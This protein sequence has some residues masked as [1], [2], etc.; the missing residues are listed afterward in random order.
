MRLRKCL[1]CK[2]IFYSVN[3]T[4]STYTFTSVQM[5]VGILRLVFVWYALLSVLSSLS[6][7]L[8]KKRELVALLFV[9]G[10]LVSVN[11]LWLFLTV[12]WVGLQCVILVFP[13]QTHLL[14]QYKFFMTQMH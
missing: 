12:S 3:T 6:I 11:V 4:K 14:F 13:H 2:R 9:F 1:I 8:K 5:F 7:I 10:C